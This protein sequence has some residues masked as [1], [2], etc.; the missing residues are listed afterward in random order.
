MHR[1]WPVI[2]QF[3]KLL[4]VG[5]D[6]KC[7][8]TWR[9]FSLFLMPN[10]DHK[11]SKP[12]N[13][14]SAL[15]VILK[16]KTGNVSPI[17]NRSCRWKR[18]S[19]ESSGQMPISQTLEKSGLEPA[20]P[21]RLADRKNCDLSTQPNPHRHTPGQP[22]SFGNFLQAK[23]L[24][25]ATQPYDLAE[26]HSTRRPRPANRFWPHQTGWWQRRRPGKHGEKR[27]PRLV[28]L[29]STRN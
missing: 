27:D 18:F 26:T 11:I 21:I 15:T 12:I 14:S 3:T 23:V 13:W 16:A 7:D 1:V 6:K 9:I 10:A 29:N 24:P 19:E 4:A 25:K 17:K 8:Q 22:F 5:V 2:R 20:E 28:A